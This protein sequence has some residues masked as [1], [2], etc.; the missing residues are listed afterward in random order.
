MRGVPWAPGS[1][2]G[3]N[4][5]GPTTRVLSALRVVAR[6]LTGHPEE[7]LDAMLRVLGPRV[8]AGTLGRLTRLYVRLSRSTRVDRLA[9]VAA[10]SR[11]RS[12]REALVRAASRGRVGYADVVAAL[13][14][15]R[16][17]QR[18]ANVRGPLDR[19]SS[20][21]SLMLAWLVFVQHPERAELLDS[22]A[23]YEWWL[24]RHPNRL[25]TDRHF[26]TLVE[27]NLALGRRDVARN[28]LSGRSNRDTPDLLLW[29]DALNPFKET[30]AE[31]GVALWL[32]ALNRLYRADEVENVELDARAGEPPF[33]RLT[34][35]PVGEV[36]ASHRVTVVVSAYRP[37][38]SLIHSIRSIATSSWRD[39]EILVVDD[40]SGAQFSR[41]F[42][43]ANA[44]DARVTIVRMET[45]GGTYRARNL[46]LDMATG[47]FITFHDSDDWMHPRRLERQ[48]LHL[49]ANP[50]VVANA[51]RS[52]RVTDRMEFSHG[53]NLGAQICEPSIMLR[54]ERALDLVGYF[55]ELRKGADAEYRR[56]IEAVLSTPTPLLGTS[57]LTLQRVTEGSLSDA[58]IVRHWFSAD[59]RVYRSCY[60]EW[61]RSTL[62]AGLPL[63]LDRAVTTARRPIYAPASLHG[64]TSEVDFDVVF[65]DNW[66]EQGTWGV[67]RPDVEAA[68]VP[69][70]A[71]GLKVGIIHL[72]SMEPIRAMHL[73]LSPSMSHLLNESNLAFLNP[74]TPS[75]ASLVVARWTPARLPSPSEDSTVAAQQL[76]V[77]VPSR[78]FPAVCR[79]RSA[80]RVERGLVRLEQVFGTPAEPTKGAGLFESVLAAL[81]LPG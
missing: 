60:E 18:R 76:L 32:D 16:N 79:R 13:A 49:I 45:N 42:E 36:P 27:V 24:A 78:L 81:R 66:L 12:G 40:A 67:S 64:E 25:L 72:P 48:A 34:A 15:F 55:D 53:R 19:L 38:A 57:P 3:P 26:R 37:D 61:H 69:L 77:I 47:E 44:V 11:S 7:R 35:R 75:R 46:A 22:L 71:R 31:R 9:R 14:E 41:L 56:R 80:K 30:N 73:A 52:S 1:R 4:Q 51:T 5:Q 50:D 10:V 2:G 8:P 74:M 28:L 6:V 29:A 23:L 39:L 58:D 70:L 65:A 54:R 43:E 21:S 20:R 63:R 68:V 59:R 62:S 17:D 33:G